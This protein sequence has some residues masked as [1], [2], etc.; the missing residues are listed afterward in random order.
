MPSILKLKKLKVILILSFLL[1]TLYFL[2]LFL[3]R[4]LSKV[5]ID[6]EVFDDPTKIVFALEE[7]R[8]VEPSV[9]DFINKNGGVEY[10]DPRDIGKIR[11]IEQSQLEKSIE[12]FRHEQSRR[13]DISLLWSINGLLLIVLVFFVFIG[14][15]DEEEFKSKV[16]FLLST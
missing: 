4:N 12:R 6:L 14:E 3:S 7:S 11:S 15:P 1:I 9:S 10:I 16:L 8:N 2:I 13:D 5:I